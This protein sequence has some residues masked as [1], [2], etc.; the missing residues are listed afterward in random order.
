M[1]VVTLSQVVALRI[2]KLSFI[3]PCKLYFYRKKG[4]MYFGKRVKLTLVKM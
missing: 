2:L 4:K 1:E 3:H